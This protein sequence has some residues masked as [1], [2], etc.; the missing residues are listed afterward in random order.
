MAEGHRHAESPSEDK[1]DY[2]RGKLIVPRTLLSYTI[3]LPL[4]SCAMHQRRPWIHGFDNRRFR[5]VV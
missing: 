4:L 3:A 1:L 2:R 5:L